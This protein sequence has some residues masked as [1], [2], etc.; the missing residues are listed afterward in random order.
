MMRHIAA[1]ALSFLIIAAIGV[2]VALS[3]GQNQ[4]RD[5]GPLATA[6]CLTVES[7]SN[8]KRVAEDLD[9]LGAVHSRFVFSVGSSYSKKNGQLKAGSFLVPAGSSSE[10]ILDIVTRGGANSC[11][12]EIVARIGVRSDRLD[13]R[14]L[15]V[16]T[17]RY[18]KVA[19]VR[20]GQEDTVIPDEIQSE[21]DEGSTNYRIVMAEGVTSFRAIDALQGLPFL[22][23]SLG[24]VPPEG[25]LAPGEYEARKGSDRASI[26]AEMTARQ[27]QIVDAAWEARAA[28][29]PI[30]SKEEMLILAS[31]IEGEAGQTN[32]EGEWRKVASV[33]VNRLNKGMR[34]EADATVRYGITLGKEKLGRGLR[35]S[36]LEKKTPYN[37]YKID[38][39]PLTPILN[40]GKAAIE[41]TV[42]PETT[43]YFFFVAD[44]TGGHAFAETLRQHRA[45]VVAWRKIEK[46][47]KEAQSE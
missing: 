27:T 40:P 26:V 8:M 21:I 5:P 12:N 20:L 1:N 44:G 19:E 24:E 41:A 17:G 32:G 25:V 10:E 13:L 22:D 15:D 47:R 2:G 3:W 23:G 38:G 30:K 39:L 18:A 28:D 11:G 7:G 4:F 35:R 6:M 34:L 43:E 9:E 14:K 46:E 45:N 29:L 31:V 37:T 36:E 16:A 42:T 33:F